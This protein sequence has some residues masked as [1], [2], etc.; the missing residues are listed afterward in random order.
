MEIYSS[1]PIAIVGAGTMGIG[2]AQVAATA[3]HP[4]TMIDQ[5]ESALARATAS[6]A[7]SL[8]G[9][10]EKG[11]IDATTRDA[12]ASRIEWSTDLTKV[13]GKALVIEA[14]VESL[15]AKRHLIGAIARVARCDTVIATN[16]SSLAIADLAEILAKPERFVGLHFFNP[17]P[18]MKLVE[19]IGGP[20]TD[21]AVIAVSERLM[22]DWGKRPVIARDVPGFI[23][24]R[25][26]RPYYAE[27]FV[28]L[29]E[30]L[31]PELIDRAL[32]EAAAFRMGPLAL[33]DMIGHDVNFAVAC[34]IHD[35]YRGNT[36][37][38]PQS[39]Q[40]SLVEAGNLGRKSSRGI[41]DYN[42]PRPIAQRVDT[43]TPPKEIAVGNAG[44]LAPLIIAAQA[45]GIAISED[46][47]LEDE[48]LRIGDSIM[49]LGD[50]RTLKQ[51]GT[52]DIILDHARDFATASVYVISARSEAHASTAASFLQSTGHDVLLVPDRPG[53]IVLRTLAQLANAAADAVDDHVTTSDGVDD[54]MMF[55]ANHPEGPL[56][57]VG[58]VG[59]DRVARALENLAVATG[60]SIYTPSTFFI[61]P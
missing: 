24:N 55:G 51:R 14:I 31:A 11:R 39:A 12:I 47:S 13:A 7:K 8:Y 30:G 35:A 3:G 54:A 17:V 58:R 33:A 52:V 41:Y 28:A 23:V 45:H 34:S 48:A 36:R 15:E 59:H 37:F 26:A 38:R 20:A 4:V 44:L 49:V 5:N 61:R 9:A 21:P 2:I 22:R 43:A 32:C 60:D 18:S 56:A 46:P 57:W 50:G 19:I 25:V 53:Q 29:D 27:A 40:R 42:K 1:S 16:T 6:I 10:V